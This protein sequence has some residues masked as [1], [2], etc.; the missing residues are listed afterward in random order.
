MWQPCLSKIGHGGGPDLDVL[1]SKPQN[2]LIAPSYRFLSFL[3][4][5]VSCNKRE[6]GY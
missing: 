1:A 3:K 2:S 4:K 5:T 6:N